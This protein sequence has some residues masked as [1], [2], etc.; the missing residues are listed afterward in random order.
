MAVTVMAL[1]AVEVAATALAAITLTGGE[2]VTMVMWLLGED[3]TVVVED[4]GAAV[5]LTSEGESGSPWLC[6]A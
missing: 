4:A 3:C 6:V 5:T 2:A 1:V